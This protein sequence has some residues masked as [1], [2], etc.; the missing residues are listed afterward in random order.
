MSGSL[1]GKNH[2]PPAP[3]P[4]SPARY[5]ERNARNVAPRCYVTFLHY[6]SAPF[7]IRAAPRVKNSFKFKASALHAPA[8]SSADA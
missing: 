4:A 1:S 8:S 6:C 3:N 2:V 5:V 7:R